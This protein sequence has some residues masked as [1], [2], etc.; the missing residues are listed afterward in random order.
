MLMCRWTPRMMRRLDRANL[1]R[2]LKK[3]RP[4]TR[5]HRSEARH[6]GR[7][8]DAIP[9]IFMP[10]SFAQGIASVAEGIG[11]FVFESLQTSGPP[12]PTGQPSAANSASRSSAADGSQDPRA[13]FSTAQRSWLDA[14]LADSIQTA[15]VRFGGHLDGQLDAIRES[16]QDA[17]FEAAEASAAVDSVRSV[18]SKAAEQSQALATRVSVQDASLRALAARLDAM[19]VSAQEARASGSGAS[20][21]GSSD[22]ASVPYEKRQHAIIANLGWDKAPT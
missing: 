22:A 1:Q 14:A 7:P 15:L 10:H 20:A 5:A 16:V 21:G 6:V 8:E 9:N 17:R 4:R 2:N 11:S 12:T 18:A 13:P 3:K 19:E